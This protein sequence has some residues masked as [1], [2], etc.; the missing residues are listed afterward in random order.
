MAVTVVECEVGC[1][2]EGRRERAGGRAG[3]QAEKEP[4]SIQIHSSVFL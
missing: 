1:G 2:V 3:G 4:I